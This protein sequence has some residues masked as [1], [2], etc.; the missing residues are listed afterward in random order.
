LD[1]QDALELFDAHPCI[2]LV[3]LDYAMPEMDGIA[4]ARE[5]KTR[6]PAVPIFMVSAHEAALSKMT[7]TC[8]DCVIL[9]GI[10]P[11]YLLEKVNQLL[12]PVAAS[13]R[14]A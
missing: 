7:L 6:R 2:E 12:V 14:T 10:G 8:V 9:K 11:A 1:G 13:R 4:V 5:M 3:L